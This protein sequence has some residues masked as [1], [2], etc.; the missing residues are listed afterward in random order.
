MAIAETRSPG[1]AI[2]DA[3]QSGEIRGDYSTYT[4]VESVNLDFVIFHDSTCLVASAQR[5][6]AHRWSRVEVAEFNV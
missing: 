4:G 6:W 2:R 5:K 3:E 1:A